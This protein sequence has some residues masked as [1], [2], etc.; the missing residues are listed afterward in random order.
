M[1]SSPTD[2]RPRSDRQPTGTGRGDDM[3]GA[4]G[5]KSGVLRIARALVWLVYAVVVAYAI[6]LG[7]A[8]VLRLL[9]ASPTAEFVDWIYRATAKIMQP[10]RGMFPPDQVTGTSVFDASLLFALIVYSFVALFLQA[11][12]DWMSTRIYRIAERQQAEA[13]P[14][15]LPSSRPGMDPSASTGAYGQ[16]SYGQGSY[17]QGSYGQDSYGQGVPPDRFPS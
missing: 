1:P 16:G 5:A 11:L 8:F 13:P 10:F 17:G 3:S 6:I 9:G 14:V 2:E 15:Q 7:T 4:E 12:V